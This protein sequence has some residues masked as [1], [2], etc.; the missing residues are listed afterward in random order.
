LNC[1]HFQSYEKFLVVVDQQI[2]RFADW[3]A[4]VLDVKWNAVV[5]HSV[6]TFMRKGW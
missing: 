2:T 5:D 3:G 1:D 6:P 4:D